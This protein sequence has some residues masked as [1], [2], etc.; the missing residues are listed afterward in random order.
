MESSEA[1][2]YMAWL[3]SRGSLLMSRNSDKAAFKD[4]A[5]VVVTSPFFP[6]KLSKGYSEPYAQV[7][8]SV[9]GI[10]IRNLGHLVQVLRD[11]TDKYIIIE[12]DG[13]IDE[14]LVFPREEMVA[15]TDEILT[16]NGI[17]AQGSAD[18]LAIWNAKAAKK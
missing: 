15:A 5:L 6:H 8:K 11:A 17:R 9:N 4:E 12:F 2:R 18:T 14:A 13:K 3:I 16:D 10:P 1:S 7:V